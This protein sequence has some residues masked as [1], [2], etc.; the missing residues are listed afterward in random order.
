MQQKTRRK[1]RQKR[2]L[3]GFS[4]A[5]CLSVNFIL[6]RSFVIAAEQKARKT[7]DNILRLSD[8]PDVNEV[9]KFLRAREVVHFQRFG[10]AL[11]SV[12]DMQD[13]K[14]VFAMREAAP[15]VCVHKVTYKE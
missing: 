12:T 15:C 5:E 8:D 9:I 7:Y 14:T 2:R 13:C 11:R 1:G 4:A 10:E 3:F 6:C